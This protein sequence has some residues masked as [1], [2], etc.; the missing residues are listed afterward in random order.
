MRVTARPTAAA[1]PSP[2][3]RYPNFVTLDHC[4][5]GAARTMS[6]DPEQGRRHQPQGSPLFKSSA[7]IRVRTRR[8]VR[9]LDV[10]GLAG[11]ACKR[12]HGAAGALDGC[13]ASFLPALTSEPDESGLT[14]VAGRTLPCTE[15]EASAPCLGAAG[16][17]AYLRVYARH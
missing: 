6:H 3:I 13:L 9:T 15:A 4:K 12:R 2:A 14:T 11:K 10:D 16:L 8:D 17:I 1:L 7:R 5:Q